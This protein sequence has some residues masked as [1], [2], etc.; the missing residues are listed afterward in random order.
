MLIA[1]N[2]YMIIEFMTT[3]SVP[4][5]RADNT[6]FMKSVRLNFQLDA[7]WTIEKDAYNFVITHFINKEQIDAWWVVLWSG[8]YLF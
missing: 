2:A 5:T 8:L 6:A 1:V 3:L 4:A 7:L